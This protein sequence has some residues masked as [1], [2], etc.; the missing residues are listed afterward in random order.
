MKPHKYALEIPMKPYKIPAQTGESFWETKGSRFHGTVCHV[1]DEAAVAECLSAE[2]KKH[3]QATAFAHAYTLGTGQEVQRFSDGGEPGGTAGLPMM[4]VLRRQDYRNTLSMVTRYF[5]G[6]HLGAGGLVRAF[7]HT[8]AL[9][10]G[11][12]GICLMQPAKVY[13]FAVAY[14]D[15]GRTAYWLEHSSFTLLDT[16]FD[17]TVTLRVR[18][19]LRDEPEF[20]ARVE[21]M[22]KGQVTPVE[23][24][25]GY[26][27]PP[28]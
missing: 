18:V 20:L 19:F 17:T 28:Q 1:P 24:E 12:A 16:A 3:P 13:R 4:E 26:F 25:M 9:A 8:C 27:A 23:M 6:V 15:H 11:Q 5:G 21:S 7:S 2:R 10:A 14:P 22:F